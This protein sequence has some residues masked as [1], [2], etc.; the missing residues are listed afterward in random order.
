M[1]SGIVPP[2]CLHL[3]YSR[4]QRISHLVRGFILIPTGVA[5]S[6]YNHSEFGSSHTILA[7]RMSILSSGVPGL[8]LVLQV[9][10]FV[11]TGFES[12]V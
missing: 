4:A 7:S 12:Q 11:L 8:I 10:S 3:L 6:S 1:G 2:V 9:A 5:S